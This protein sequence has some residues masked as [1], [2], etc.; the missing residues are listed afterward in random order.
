[1]EEM[2][3]FSDKKVPS[4]DPPATASCIEA[5]QLVLVRESAKDSILINHVHFYNSICE[6]V[7]DV[8]V[9][10]LNWK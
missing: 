4:N 7:H 5:P 8:L 6:V 10:N 1:M 9:S 2:L 3:T